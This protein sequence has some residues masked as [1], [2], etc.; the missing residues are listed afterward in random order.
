MISISYYYWM[1]NEW[2]KW[3]SQK[4]YLF[5]EFQPSWVTFAV[6]IL[7]TE[8]PNFTQTDGFNHLIEQLLSS[9]RRLDSELQL[10]IHRRHSDINLRQI[11]KINFQLKKKK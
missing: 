5:V 8:E 3:I 9:G 4:N 10:R 11:F 6:C 2:T 7:Q 1:N